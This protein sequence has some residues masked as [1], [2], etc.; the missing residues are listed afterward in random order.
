MNS[1]KAI[2]ISSMI[3]RPA[4]TAINLPRDWGSWDLAEVIFAPAFAM[5]LATGLVIGL[6][7]T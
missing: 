6:A 2:A 3:T 7:V 1:P 4:M 5:G